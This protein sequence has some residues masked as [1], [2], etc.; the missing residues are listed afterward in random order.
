MG[1][2]AQWWVL[3]QKIVYAATAT[4]ALAHALPYVW[5]WSQEAGIV[6]DVKP[7]LGLWPHDLLVTEGWARYAHF[8][9]LLVAG[10]LMIAFG[11]PLGHFLLSK[12]ENKLYPRLKVF[13]EASIYI[14]VAF[15][16]QAAIPVQADFEAGLFG[17]KEKIC[18]PSTILHFLAL[19]LLLFAVV[20]HGYSNLMLMHSSNTLPCRRSTAE[21]LFRLRCGLVA[22]EAVCAFLVVYFHPINPWRE[23]P[24]VETPF[25]MQLETDGPELKA[26]KASVD[27]DSFGNYA[28]ITFFAFMVRTSRR[29]CVFDLRG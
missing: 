16:A 23:S 21:G 11:M 22:T 18:W 10:A 7:L 26:L 1:Y 14:V 27:V 4:L 28:T 24:I 12:V 9:T 2:G 15:V 3:S 25:L 17:K 8:V 6:S 19:V 5:W 13:N 20:H 29:A